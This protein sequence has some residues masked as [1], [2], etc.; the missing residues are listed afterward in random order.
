MGPLHYGVTVTVVARVLWRLYV[1]NDDWEI[2]LSSEPS[3]VACRF[4]LVQHFFRLSGGIAACSFVE[5]GRH[6]A[7]WKRKG[8]SVCVSV[9]QAS[10]TVHTVTKYYFFFLDICGEVV[11]RRS[12]SNKDWVF[13]L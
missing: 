1:V 9:M 5:N 12:A 6:A 13:L 7:S 11:P 10:S 4:V 2:S 3:L 8:A